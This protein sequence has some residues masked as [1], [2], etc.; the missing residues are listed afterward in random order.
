MVKTSAMARATK[1]WSKR[2]RYAYF[3]KRYEAMRAGNWNP[4]NKPIN[5]FKQLGPS[6]LDMPARLSPRH[7]ENVA[8]DKFLAIPCSVWAQLEARKAG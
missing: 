1:P 3:H 2:K 6:R 4:A 5:P 8:L 7:R